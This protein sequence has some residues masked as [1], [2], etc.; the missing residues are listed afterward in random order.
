MNSQV[1]IRF[2]E[3]FMHLSI[4][5]SDVHMYSPSVVFVVFVPLFG[6]FVFVL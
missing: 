5:L 3:M 2:F 4:V 1:L 6:Y